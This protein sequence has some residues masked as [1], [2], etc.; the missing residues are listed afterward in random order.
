VTVLNCKRLEAS[1]VSY[2]F[3]R[4]FPF[5]IN[6]VCFIPAVGILVGHCSKNCN[7]FRISDKEFLSL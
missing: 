2:W 1:F 7:T 3:R 6:V 4:L 5:I